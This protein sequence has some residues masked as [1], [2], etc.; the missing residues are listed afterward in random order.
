MLQDHHQ[1]TVNRNFELQTFKG[2][3]LSQYLVH[4]PFTEMCSIVLR[5][6]AS[7]ILVL[8]GP[9]C[10]L[11]MI[12]HKHVLETVASNKISNLVTLSET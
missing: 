5:L 12:D 8:V 4:I 11:T 10:S 9:W 1:V 2:N 7:M 3:S 6:Y